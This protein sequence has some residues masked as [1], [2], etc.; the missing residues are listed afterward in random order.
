M[1]KTA[2]R[3]VIALAAGTVLAGVCTFTAFADHEGARSV[4]QILKDCNTA[5]DFCEFRIKDSKDGVAGEPQAVTE[6]LSNCT[7]SDVTKSH[8]VAHT[9]GTTTNTGLEVGVQAGYE[10]VFQAS[11]KATLNFEWSQSSTVE[12]Q[13]TMTVKAGNVGAMVFRP[14][15]RQVVGDYEVHYGSRQQG[16]FFWFA[17]NVTWTGPS[18]TKK[19]NYSVVERPMTEA[20]LATCQAGAPTDLVSLDMT[21]NL[22]GDGQPLGNQVPLNQALAVDPAATPGE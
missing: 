8:K 5:T 1:R 3:G 6:S 21:V 13:I 16:H 9:V 11:V 20:E 7:Q 10:T 18:E 2:R 4:E 17:N 12:D 22:N 15:L 19:G 14:A